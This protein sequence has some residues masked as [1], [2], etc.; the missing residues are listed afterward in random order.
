MILN[1]VKYSSAFITVLFGFHFLK[2]ERERILLLL[3]EKDDKLLNCDKRINILEKELVNEKNKYNAIIRLLP[4]LEPESPPDT[5][6]YNSLD[7]DV[8]GVDGV[9]DKDEE[10]DTNKTNYDNDIVN[11]LQNDNSEDSIE[12][13]IHSN[14]NNDENNDE[15]I[16]ND[17]GVI[18]FTE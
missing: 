12:E 18:E 17:R 11:D 2:T 16:N 6:P 5:T 8:D 13:L 9:K 15:E 10:L 1:V 3:K 4:N 14:D 7:E